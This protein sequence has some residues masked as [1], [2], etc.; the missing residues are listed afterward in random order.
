[1]FLVEG[2]MMFF[3]PNCVK[4]VGVSTVELLEKSSLIK[5]RKGGGDFVCLTVKIRVKH[6]SLTCMVKIET[7]ERCCLCVNLGMFLI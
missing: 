2:E 4:F 1:M 3:S 5:T 6:L 7:C